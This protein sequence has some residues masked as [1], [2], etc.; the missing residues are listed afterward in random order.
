MAL[1]SAVLF[2]PSFPLAR[3]QSLVLAESVPSSHVSLRRRS[4]EFHFSREVARM[5]CSHLEIWRITSSTSSFL[6]ATSLCLGVACGVHGLDSS[7]DAT[8]S[9][10]VRNAWLDSG[11]LLYVSSGMFFGRIAHIFFS[12][13]DSDRDVSR[14]YATHGG[15]AGSLDSQATCHQS[16]S[17][18]RASLLYFVAIHTAHLN[19][20]PKQ[21]QQQHQH[22]GCLSQACP[23]FL[24]RHQ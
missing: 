6:A 22:E 19:P 24:L 1:A 9:L 18:T 13:V 11:Y 3:E 20:S 17:V 10:F 14:L 21:Q 12:E 5:R 8:M 23:L 15:V 4:E 16:D 7:G 2:A